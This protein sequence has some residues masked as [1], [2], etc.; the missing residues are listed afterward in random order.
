VIGSLSPWGVRRGDSGQA[1][2]E[3]A[4]ILPVVT[5]MVLMGLDFSRV[6]HDRLIMLDAARAGAETAAAQPAPPYAA[7]A[8]AVVAEAPDLP[9]PNDPSHVQVAYPGDGTAQVLVSYGFQ[10]L[11]P[12]V[13]RTWGGGPL[14]IRVSASWPLGPAGSQPTPLPTPSAQPTITPTP[15]A[16]ST[17]TAMPTSTATATATA[18]PTATGTAMATPTAGPTATATATAAPTATPTQVPA[19]T[20]TPQLACTFSVNQSLTAGQGFYVVVNVPGGTATITASYKAPST[21]TSVAIYLYAG[22]SAFAGDPPPPV[23]LAPPPGSIASAV[24]G[25]NTATV[26]ANVIPGVSVYTVYFYT[27][28]DVVAS[29]NSVQQTIGCSP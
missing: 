23:M 2:V 25:S 26:T 24:I 14:M 15:M 19:A 18:G 12:L 17:P 4:L 13:A 21:T 5:L 22:G 7:V 28:V 20:P 27:T 8:G 6:M 1:I 16:T 9:I 10:A 3:F 29:G 11:T